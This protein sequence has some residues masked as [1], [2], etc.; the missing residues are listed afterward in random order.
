MGGMSCLVSDY[1]IGRTCAV[2][3]I[4]IGAHCVSTDHHVLLSI[5]DI[6]TG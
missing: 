3:G 1:Y 5:T 4:E 2:T 6:C